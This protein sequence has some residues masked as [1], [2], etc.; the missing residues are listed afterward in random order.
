VKTVPPVLV[1]VSSLGTVKTSV[2]GTTTVASAVG[3]SYVEVIV[4][5]EVNS[6]VLV[7]VTSGR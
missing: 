5:A 4:Y 3:R 1:A 6:I 2:T 7:S